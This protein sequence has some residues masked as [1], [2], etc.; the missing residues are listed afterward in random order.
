MQEALDNRLDPADLAEL[1]RHLDSSAGDSAQFQRLKQV[2]RTL[3]SAPHERAP[4]RM[5]AAVMAQLG[6]ALSARQMP[7]VSGLALAL[8]L[9]LAAA[10]VLPALLAVGWLLLSALGNAALLASALQ[11]AAGLIVLGITLAEQAI[12]GVQTLLAAN[13]AAVL[14]LLAAVPVSLLWLLL[15]GPRLRAERTL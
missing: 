7:R 12:T 8:G 6:E 3:R 1:Y 13:T 10:A 5:A 2:D 14:L 9:A 15:L 4:Q 11:T